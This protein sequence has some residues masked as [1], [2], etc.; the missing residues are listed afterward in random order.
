MT[1]G[2]EPIKEVLVDRLRDVSK[3]TKAEK[4]TWLDY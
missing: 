2:V 3:H 4:H 1:Y